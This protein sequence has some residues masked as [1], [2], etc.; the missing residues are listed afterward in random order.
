MMDTLSSGSILAKMAK[1]A[2]WV[3]GWRLVT[4]LLGVVNTLTLAHELLPSDF[5]LV[6]L[7]AG[8]AGAVDS[9]SALGVEES[10]IRIKEPS[11]ELYN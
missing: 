9:L 11:R 7:G 10:V 5:G 8:F 3:I 4:R 6:A 1:G 2:G